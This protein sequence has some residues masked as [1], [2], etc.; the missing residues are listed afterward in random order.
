MVTLSGPEEHLDMLRT[1]L[2]EQSNVYISD[3][4]ECLFVKH[5]NH[6]NLILFSCLCVAVLIMSCDFAFAITLGTLTYRELLRIDRNISKNFRVLQLKLLTAVVAQTLVP[7]LFVVVPYSVCLLLPLFDI[8][9]PG[10]SSYFS[11]FMTLFP[12]WDAIVILF[13]MRDYRDGL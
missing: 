12:A 8:F 4:W 2:N 13:I 3:A 11:I 10:F 7:A 5:D 6:L 9:D 1:N